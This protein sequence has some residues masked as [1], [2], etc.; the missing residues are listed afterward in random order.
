MV[1]RLTDLLP[2]FSGASN[3]CCCFLHIVNLVA[4]SILKQF[5]VPDNKA[6]ATLNQAECELINLA[7]GIDMEEL[8][9]RAEQGV[10]GDSEGNDN[11]DGWVNETVLFSAVE[12]EQPRDDIQPVC[13]VL[14][15]VSS[16]ITN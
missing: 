3:R 6:N 9:T 14:K 1:N 13:L 7:A 11:D 15:K 4:K 10:G 16:Y 5:D 2:N 8:L 12:R